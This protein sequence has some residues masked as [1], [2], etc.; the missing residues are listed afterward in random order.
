MGGLPGHSR[1]RVRVLTMLGKARGVGKARNPA[2]GVARV[3]PDRPGD[4]GLPRSSGIVA[5]WATVLTLGQGNPGCY[6]FWEWS[7]DWAKGNYHC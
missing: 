1:L 7:A 5:R 3:R 4:L 6:N 2:R